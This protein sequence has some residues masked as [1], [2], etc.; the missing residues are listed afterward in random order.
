MR[1]R[2]VGW[3]ARGLEFARDL[4]RFFFRVVEIEIGGVERVDD[5]MSS[6]LRLTVAS[7]GRWRGCATY[8]AA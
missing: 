8:R 5:G 1:F 4:A 3:K 7:A 6:T 2:V